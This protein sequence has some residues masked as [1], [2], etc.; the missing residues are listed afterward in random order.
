MTI[1]NFFYSLAFAAFLAAIFII[2]LDG[3]L[4]QAGY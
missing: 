2:C 1:K 3:S 4:S